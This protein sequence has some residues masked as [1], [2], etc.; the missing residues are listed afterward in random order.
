MKILFKCK[1]NC[2]HKLAYYLPIDNLDLLYLENLMK[3]KLFLRSK[4]LLIQY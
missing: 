2:L 1:S 3:N 4:Y